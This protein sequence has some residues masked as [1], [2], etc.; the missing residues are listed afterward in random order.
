VADIIVIDSATK[1]L[2]P[3]PIDQP[4]DPGPT[5][6]PGIRE[7]PVIGIP[8]PVPDSEATP[9]ID[10]ASQDDLA[11]LIEPRITDLNNLDIKVDIGRIEDGLLPEPDEF[12]AYE[13]PPEPVRT[14]NPEYP[15]LARRAG[16]EGY[17]WLQVLVDKEGKVRDVQIYKDSGAKA[18][19]EEAAID[20]AYRCV[21]KPAIANGAPVAVWITYKVVFKLG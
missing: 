2:P 10:I 6:D 19:F 11:G 14:V 16:I 20:A 17:L 21:W 9:D 5:V 15:D 12:I 1:I 8:E 18:G 4:R 7:K 13:Y 3:P